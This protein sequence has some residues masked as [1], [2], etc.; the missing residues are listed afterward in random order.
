MEKC[1]IKTQHLIWVN[2]F[3]EGFFATNTKYN[4]KESNHNEQEKFPQ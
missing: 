4:K 2:H 3:Q 1:Y